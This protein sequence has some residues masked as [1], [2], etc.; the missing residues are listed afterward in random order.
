[1]A[2]NKRW[3]DSEVQYLLD[4]VKDDPRVLKVCFSKVAKHLGRT[5]AGVANK[6]YQVT[7]D[8]T[9]DNSCFSLNSKKYVAF[10]R[11]QF[12]EKVTKE[13]PK[14]LFARIINSIFKIKK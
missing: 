3:S 7:V 4:K 10:N 9:K 6:Y 5:P 14:G 1:M 11:K 8:A 2:N 12:S 13:A